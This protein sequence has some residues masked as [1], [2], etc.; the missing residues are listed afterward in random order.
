MQG[1]YCRAPL[2]RKR[3]AEKQLTSILFLLLCA[4]QVLAMSHFRWY[5]FL[6]SSPRL[7]AGTHIDLKGVRALR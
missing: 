3:G 7:F 6:R 1:R 4:A 5:D 2:E